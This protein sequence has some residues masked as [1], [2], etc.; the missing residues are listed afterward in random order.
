MRMSLLGAVL[1]VL[2]LLVVPVT[3]DAGAQAAPQA[4]VSSVPRPDHVVI[5]VEEN[6]ALGGVVGNANAPYITSLAQQNAN[7]TQSYAETHPSE[8]NYLALFSGSTQGLTNDSCPH[9]Y[10]TPDLGSSAIAAG[11]GFAGYSEALP[12]VGYTGCSSGT[13]A[14]KHNPWVNFPAV[15]ASAN[16]PF[17]A[18]PSDYSTLPAV[19]FVVPDLTHD[20]HDGTIAQGDTWL[21]QNLGGY[22]T[23]AK[24]HNSLFVLTFDED[25]GGAA[26]R[27]PTVLAGQRVVPG[28]YAEQINHYNLLRT[29]TDAYGLI[30]PGNAATA[31]PI[32]DVWSAP[33]GDTPPTAAFTSPCTGLTCTVD[34]SGTTDPDGTVAGY[35][36]AFGDGTTGSGVTTS[37]TYATGGSH[38]IT[39]TA[40][41]DQGATGSVT[42]SVSTTAPA[43]AAFASDTFNRT[44]ANGWGS[45]DVGGAYSVAGTAADF[46]VTPGVGTIRLS[47]LGATDTAILPSTT[48]TDTDLALTVAADKVPAGGPVYTNVI[49]RRVS[50][51][52]EYDTRLAF[53]AAGEVIVWLVRL[54]G[55]T[56]TTLTPQT[57][58]SGLTYTAGTALTVRTQVVGTAPTTVRARVWKAGTAEPDAWNATTTDATAVLQTRGAVGLRGSPSSKVTNTPVTL[59]FSSLAA[60]PTSSTA[61][62]PPAAA[63]TSVCT[64]L[65]CTLDG[66]TSSD[67]DGSVVGWAW[68]FG[69]GATGSGAAT[70]HAWVTG[71]TYPVT[72]VVTDDHGATASVQHDVT[73]TTPPPEAP[74]T[75]A[76]TSTCSGLTCTFDGSGSK[77]GDGDPVVAWAWDLGDTATASTSNPTH[78]F[79][80]A[81]TYTVRLAVTDD[82]GGTASVTHPV[83]VTTGPPAP[84]VV[85]ADDFARTVSGGWGRAT[86]GGAWTVA[87]GAA[88]TSVS[89]GSATMRPAVGQ[90]ISAYLTS[91]SGSAADLTTSV[92]LDKLPAAGPM[93]L[94]VVAR[95]VASAGNAEYDARLTVDASGGVI[96]WLVKVV[97]GVETALTPQTRIAGLT[98]TVGNRLAIRVSAA[99]ATPTT[100]QAKAWLASGAEPATWNASVTDATAA[101]QAPGYLGVRSNPSSKVTNAPITVSFGP[102]RAVAG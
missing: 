34:A 37:H 25:D 36:W 7:F 97:G 24:T 88:N 83:T 42:H 79:A 44:V 6:H 9:T 70:S 29:I 21:Q 11:I 69:D 12:S 85:A 65:S 47:K 10:S 30:A 41:D 90:T 82:Y 40:T 2:A 98:V 102:L 78:T 3:Q 67:T 50:S 46:S 74:P 95:R 4:A 81:G 17:S 19:S 23:W 94:G 60:T 61:N 35:S 33:T 56:E 62:T 101:L 71:G 64:Q 100:L 57:R 26:N 73:V 20:M 91:A 96:L 15:P 53:G 27:I 75:A 31:P 54:I 87:G 45:A 52:N 99:G 18:F 1:L 13:Y 28:D 80:A 86:V 38:A 8:P 93:Y 59:S 55:G 22:V 72:L 32:T 77:D 92:A 84:T 16:Q 5:V 49:G 14:R 63:F 48:S 76:F 39:L 58:I 68:D 89:S 51:G 43:G 66:S